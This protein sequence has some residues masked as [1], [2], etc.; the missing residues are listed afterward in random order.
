MADV[1]LKP[2]P[3]CKSGPSVPFGRHTNAS[4]SGVEIV[5]ARDGNY[6]QCGTCGYR[7]PTFE[8]ESQAIAAWNTRK[9]AQ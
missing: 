5:S 2:C 6:V 3:E 1:E 7:L 8:T 4:F 9:D